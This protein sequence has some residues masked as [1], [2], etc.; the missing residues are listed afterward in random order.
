MHLDCP[1]EVEL[2]D[3]VLYLFHLHPRVLDPL[4]SIL[5]FLVLVVCISQLPSCLYLPTL[6][7]PKICRLINALLVV[8]QISFDGFPRHKHMYISLCFYL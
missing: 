6:Y 3:S 5:T 8:Q 1:G 7:L 2:Q 4:G